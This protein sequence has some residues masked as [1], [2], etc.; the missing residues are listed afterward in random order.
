MKKFM[1][2]TMIIICV[3]TAGCVDYGVIAEAEETSA[4][5]PTEMLTVPMSDYEALADE[6]EQLRAGFAEME[7][8][9]EEAAQQN[10]EALDGISVIEDALSQVELGIYRS[11]I[12]KDGIEIYFGAVEHAAQRENG[13]VLIEA[14]ALKQTNKTFDSSL[15]TR[16]EIEGIN[17][18]LVFSYAEMKARDVVIGADALIRY[19][20]KS[21]PDLDNGFFPYLADQIVQAEV[22]STSEGADEDTVYYPIFIFVTLDGNALMVLEK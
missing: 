15:Y 11:V 21:Y 1:I 14:Y 20:G 8:Q 6:N 9:L 7:A 19:N 22:A 10:A 2:F 16:E 3:M 18:N 4:P 17:D 12:A 13:D 5:E